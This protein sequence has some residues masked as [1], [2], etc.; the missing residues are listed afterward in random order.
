MD[1][2]A[3]ASCQ[4]GDGGV[5]LLAFGAFAGVVGLGGRV[6]A[7]GDPR[8]SEECVLELLVPGSG[9]EFAPDGGPGTPGDG[10]DAG[11]GGELA[12]GPEAAG[13]PMVRSMV[14]AVLMPTP[15]MDIKTPESGSRPGAFRLPLQRWPAGV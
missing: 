1:D 12:G 6:V 4:A 9:R 7:G 10:G 5:V 8:G 11:V 2:V 15:G 13:V 3:A 14:A